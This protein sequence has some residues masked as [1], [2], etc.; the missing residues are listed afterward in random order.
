MHVPYRGAAPAV[1]DLI[2]GHVSMMFDIQTLAVPQVTAGKVRALAVAAPRRL[3]DLPDVPT[4]AEAGMPELE[5]GP[6]FGLLVPAGTPRPIVEWLNAEATKAFS[7]PE[8]RDRLVA[9]G[10][11]LPLGSPEDFSATSRRRPSAGATSS[12]PRVFEWSRLEHDPEK[13]EPVFG[14]IMLEQKL[15]HDPIQS[16]RIMV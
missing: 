15:D 10:L 3:A 11:T 14:K 13:W 2:A 1:Q 8:M 9:Q 12:A 16:D 7:S 5:G 6:W 4:T